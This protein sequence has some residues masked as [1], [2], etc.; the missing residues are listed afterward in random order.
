MPTNHEMPLNVE[1][2]LKKNH[3]KLITFSEIPRQPTNV[4]DNKF[5]D[6]KYPYMHL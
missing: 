1:R 2:T 6:I 5:A 3:F 4:G